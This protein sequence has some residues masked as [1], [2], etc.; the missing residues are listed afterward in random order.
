MCFLR[1]HRS[2]FFSEISFLI[3][4]VSNT[5]TVVVCWMSKHIQ[6]HL[7]SL[8][9]GLC[10]LPFPSLSQ[11]TNSSYNCSADWR[12]EW[13]RGFELLFPLFTDF[14]NLISPYFTHRKQ[15]LSSA[16]LQNT[17]HTFLSAYEAGNYGF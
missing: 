12:R 17:V 8:T 14:F 2:C 10:I 13:T 11:P 6:R 15:T 4:E 7:A 5:V 16:C 1:K 3:C 9:L